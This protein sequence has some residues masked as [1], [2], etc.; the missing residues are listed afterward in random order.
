LTRAVATGT[1][2]KAPLVVVVVVV[3]VVVDDGIVDDRLEVVIR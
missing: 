2:V 1:I 3:V